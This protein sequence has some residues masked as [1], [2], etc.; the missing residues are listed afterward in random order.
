M[1]KTN[2]K[3]KGDFMSETEHSRK[4]ALYRRRQ[5]LQKINDLLQMTR[6]ADPTELSC[7]ELCFWTL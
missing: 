5:A 3:W 2:I 4:L 6:E 7:F 1:Q